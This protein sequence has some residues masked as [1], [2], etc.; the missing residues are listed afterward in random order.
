MPELEPR[1]FSFNSPHGA[2]AAL[3]GL[4]SR[5]ADRPGPR[6]P[7]PTSKS[8][9]DG[10][11]SG[12][13]VPFSLHFD[14]LAQA[15]GEHVRRRPRLPVEGPLR[16]GPRDLPE[17]HSA[18]ERIQ[19]TYT[20]RA[21]T[22]RTYMARSR[23]SSRRPR[24]PLRRDRLR[25]RARVHRAGHGA[26]S[27]APPATARA[28]GRSRARCAST[29][30]ASTSSRTSRRAA[31]LEWI[32]ERRAQQHRAPDRA[33]D[34]PR[35]RGAPAASSTT[36]ASATCRWT[37]PRPR[38][39]AARRSASGSR[40]RSARSLVGV[41][42]ILDEPSIGLHQRDNER[43]IAT[44]ERLRDL[45]NTVIVVEHDEG[46]MLRGRPDRR[47]RPRRRRARRRDRRPGH[48]RSRSARSRSR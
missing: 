21:A 10:A 35:D 38:S 2:C 6:G 44:L 32:D 1:I 36:S 40:R 4:G 7:G 39:P 30:S 48:G 33:A 3:H 22:T 29:A 16:R 28:C 43:L 23:A 46:T 25:Q 18:S 13:L 24:A 11:I 14:R 31:A 45:G 27:R 19:V 5:C 42:Y 47:H 8:I 26:A 9:A 41:L 12:W 20:N 37:A 15:V 17:R 34:P